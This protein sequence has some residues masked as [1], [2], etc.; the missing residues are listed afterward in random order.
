MEVAMNLSMILLLGMLAPQRIH[1]GND[2]AAPNGVMAPQVVSYTEPFYTRLARDNRIE[3]TVTFEASFDA[4]GNMTVLRTLRTLGYGLDENAAAALRSWKFSPALRNGIPVDAIAEI[5][6]DFNLADAPP[7]EYDDV[8]R[9]GPG[10]SA[11][12]VL[13]RVEP[14]YTEEAR[15]A[16]R[17]GTVVLQAVVGSDGSAKVL[18]IVKPLDLGLTESAVT[19]IEQWKFRP[20]MR[21]GKEVPVS[22]N[23]EVNFNLENRK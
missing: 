3:G 16:H 21:N 7:A 2:P 5:E 10:V 19:A 22:L 4:K 6:V 14:Q 23:I 20:A 18:K 17:S 13:T 12:T 9:V 15:A 1:I 8:A 11:P